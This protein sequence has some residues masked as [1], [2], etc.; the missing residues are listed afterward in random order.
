M[1]KVWIIVCCNTYYQT[2]FRFQA[3]APRREA[4]ANDNLALSLVFLNLLR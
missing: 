3:K 2:D 1:T 4:L